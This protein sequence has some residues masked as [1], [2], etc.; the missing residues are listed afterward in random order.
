VLQPAPINGRLER[1]RA[2]R[3]EL[4]GAGR[5]AGCAVAD[6]WRPENER[7]CRA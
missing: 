4:R 5:R 1:A 6:D 3:H 2:G 7:R